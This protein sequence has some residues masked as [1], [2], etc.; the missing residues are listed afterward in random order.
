MNAWTVAR[1]AAIHIAEGNEGLAAR[2]VQLALNDARNGAEPRLVGLEDDVAK[3]K[4]ALA[5]N[6]NPTPSERSDW[7]KHCDEIWAA[8]GT[9]PDE[10]E[11]RVELA[12]MELER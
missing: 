7:Q 11:W 10:D 9:P 4:Q 2:A 1:S 5:S 12:L 3:L 6:Y 8:G